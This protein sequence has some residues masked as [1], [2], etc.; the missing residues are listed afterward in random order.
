MRSGR[1]RNSSGDLTWVGTEMGKIPSA[2]RAHPSFQHHWNEAR[3]ALLRFQT[4]LS[5]ASQIQPFHSPDLQ[6]A[7][8]TCSDAPHP[9]PQGFGVMGT[10]R[11]HPVPSS[12]PGATGPE[13]LL[14]LGS[15]PSSCPSCLPP[16]S[17]KLWDAQCGKPKPQ[18][19]Q[20]LRDRETLALLAHRKVF[21]GGPRG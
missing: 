9:H 20:G 5:C 8:I 7:V 14:P 19:V 1:H 3:G 6:G 12:P 13:L 15:G 18:M 4:Q 17:G 21:P 11:P 16:S 10:P 2:F